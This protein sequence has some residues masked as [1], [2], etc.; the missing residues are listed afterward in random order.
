M[1]LQFPVRRR[2]NLWIA[3][4]MFPTAKGRNQSI[5]GIQK[6][7]TH[8]WIRF[9]GVSEDMD[10]LAALFTLQGNIELGFANKIAAMTMWSKV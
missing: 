1:E 5:R 7:T 3:N 9:H 10:D 2:R 6:D 4:A 8:R